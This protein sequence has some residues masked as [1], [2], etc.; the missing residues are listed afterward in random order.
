MALGNAVHEA[1]D[2][3]ETLK[4]I[5]HASDTSLEAAKLQCRAPAS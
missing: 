5:L 3:S 1:L 2:K 4:N